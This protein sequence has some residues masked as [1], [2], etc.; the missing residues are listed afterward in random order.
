M[1]EKKFIVSIRGVTGVDGTKGNKRGA[2]ATLYTFWNA[3][4]WDSRG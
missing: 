4:K 3:R 1:F 2:D